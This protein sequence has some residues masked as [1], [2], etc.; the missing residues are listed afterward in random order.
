MT[1]SP[2]VH[3]SRY[4]LR[5]T[6]PTFAS[7]LANRIQRDRGFRFARQSVTELHRISAA[8]YRAAAAALA[9]EPGKLLAAAGGTAAGGLQSAQAQLSDLVRPHVN[10]S[11]R[12]ADGFAMARE[13]F[14]RLA[15]L[16]RGDDIHNRPDD[17]GGVAGGR[18][19][20][21]R[22]FVHH[23]AEAGRFARQNGQRLPLG[24]DA[25]AINPGN[26]FV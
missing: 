21:R 16:N 15:G 12:A 8:Q 19:T 14:H 24:P 13:D 20:R 7:F 18:R 22:R 6:S 2:I 17:A 3:R 26:V 5:T 9:G 1:Y 4:L 11:Q 25:A 23:A 10:H